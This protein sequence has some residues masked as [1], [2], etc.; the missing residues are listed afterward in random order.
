MFFGGVVIIT[1]KPFS[2]GDWIE[3]SS[4]EGVVEDI[5]FRSTKVRTF[6]QALV[7]VPNSVL[8]NEAITNW[9]K[10][11]RR[12]ISFKLG[13]TYSTP[14]E[15]LDKC[16]TEIREMLKNHSDIHPQTIFV[17]FDGFNDSSLDIFLY[18]F[19]K[20]TDWGEFFK[21]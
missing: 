16:I 11:G 21:Y 6:A 9:T 3:S 5:N 20:S 18:F 8:A 15:K 13:V 14:K 4:V 2:I 12:Q 7:T 17:N 19:T 1:D 10:M